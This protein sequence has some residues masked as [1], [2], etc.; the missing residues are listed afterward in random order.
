MIAVLQQLKQQGII[1]ALDYH[2]A[3]FIAE[4]EAHFEQCSTQ[5]QNLLL[6]VASLLSFHNQN[7]SVCLDLQQ[8]L[9]K[10]LF[11]LY[12]QDP[13]FQA[14]NTKIE[15][16]PTQQWAEQ[17]QGFTAVS[18]TVEKV[19]PIL[20]QHNRLYLR[21]NWSDEQVIANY[22]FKQGKFT[23]DLSFAEEQLKK[24]LDELYPPSKSGVKEDCIDWQKIAVA[25]ALKQQVCLI[26][27]GPGTGK[28]RTVCNLLLLLQWLC[29]QQGTSPLSMAIAAPTGKAASRLNESISNALND[30]T[31]PELMA[32]KT[33]IPQEGTTIHRLLGINPNSETPRYH[34]NNPLPVD[35]L[36]IDEA[37][38]IDAALMSKVLQA[39]PENCRLILLGDKD[40]LTS[41]E[42]GAVISELYRFI[43][44]DYSKLQQ[45]YLTQ[46]CGEHVPKS[47][48]EW[49]TFRDNLCYLLKS[50]RFAEDSAIKALADAVNQGNA[51]RSWQCFADS[52]KTDGQLQ[53]FD[54]P[55]SMENITDNAVKLIIRQTT[56]WYKNYLVAVN[57]VEK[58]NHTQVAKIFTLFNQFRL[59]S[60]LRQ[61]PFGTEQLNQVLCEHL[62]G[63][64][65][66][67]YHHI[68]EWF[69]GKVVMVTRND[70]NVGLYNGDIGIFLQD[71]EESSRGHVWFQTEKSS[72]DNPHGLRAILASRIPTHELAF[73]MTVHK[74]Q[75][76]EFSHTAL[77]LPNYS[78]PLL[79]RELVYTAITRSKE[80]FTLFGHYREWQR[81]VMNPER[82]NSGLYAQLSEYYQI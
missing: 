73:V 6:L 74:S 42:A 26:S 4:H 57:Q 69:N 19:T 50:Y 52:A 67:T 24:L 20:L 49:V 55:S 39:V 36:L 58:I 5:Q 37:S 44:E 59:L 40:Q 45:T 53:Q 15:Y 82:R 18:S 47:F 27:G 16:L 75:G 77:A 64:G 56:R 22:L 29:Q 79:S 1:T 65:L 80:R 28:T 30:I 60:A 2:F 14:I 3:L 10:Q 54:Y 8:N 31:L 61:G 51:K 7:G 13:L 63:Q 35:L 70:L 72:A 12:S 68:N 21:R 34:Q 62:R 17:L 78:N 11:N 38:M 41:V 76:S 43:S 66:L 9:E 23:F 81:A 46:V 32:I 71:G 25:T 33:H 48:Q